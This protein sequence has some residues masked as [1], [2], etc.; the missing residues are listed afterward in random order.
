MPP[1]RA[2]NSRDDQRYG[3]RWCSTL[4]RA[5]YRLLLPSF[6]KRLLHLP[7]V[8][9]RVSAQRVS[10]V[11]SP[12]TNSDSEDAIRTLI[13]VCDGNRLTDVVSYARAR[14]SASLGCL[15][16]Q[17]TCMRAFIVLRVGAMARSVMTAS[18]WSAAS[19]LRPF[20]RRTM[21]RSKRPSSGRIPYSCM[22]SQT[23]HV[24]LMG[25]KRTACN[26][27]IS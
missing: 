16:K 13:H 17:A 12:R 18:C 15:L 14:S 25:L 20:A 22:V 1:V 27:G 9:I 8:S 3:E 7:S 19:Q 23:A 6:P 21:R 2:K 24:S 26:D 11:C 5:R 10:L 4:H